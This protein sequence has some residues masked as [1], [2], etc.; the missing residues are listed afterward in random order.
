[1]RF[2]K[3]KYK[4]RL[5]EVLIE[6]SCAKKNLVVLVDEKLD[7]SQ[8]CTHAAWKANSILDCI[9]RGMT[10]RQREVIVL[11]YSSLVRPH[12]KYYV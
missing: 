6:R 8:Q 12:L 10:S 2:N 4:Y 3:A 1:M 5:R 11:L 9:K 7:I